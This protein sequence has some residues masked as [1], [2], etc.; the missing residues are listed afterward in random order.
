M[1]GRPQTFHQL[2]PCL[3]IRDTSK[4]RLRCRMDNPGTLLQLRLELAARPAGVSDKSSKRLRIVAGQALR[5][6]QRELRVKSHSCFTGDPIESYNGEF[7]DS[8]RS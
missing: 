6:I 7:M 2:K 8:H 3:V 5:L 1:I 4:D